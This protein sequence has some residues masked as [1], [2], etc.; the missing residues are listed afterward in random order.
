MRAYVRPC[1]AAAAAASLLLTPLPLQASAASRQAPAAP[2][3]AAV[4]EHAGGLVDD[5][6]E[7]V[8]RTYSTAGLGFGRTVRKGRANV[9]VGAVRQWLGLD[10]ANGNYYRK[11]FTL[12]AVGEHIEVWVAND[13]R[14]PER[15]CRPRDSTDVT[16][17]QVG[18]LVHEF[19]TT[20]WPRETSAF[21][22]PPGRDGTDPL[23]TGD[24][25]GDGEKTVTLV[26]NVRDDNFYT[27]PKAPTYIAGFFSPQINE[28]VDRN[29]MTIDAYDWKHRTGA[30]PPDEPTG[31]V[32]TSRPARPRMYEGTF[33]HEWQHLL[34]QYTDPD[35]VTWVNE[36]L[37]DYAQTLVGYVDASATI[38]HPGA[39]TH[40]TCFQGFAVVETKYN[41]NPRE[42]G[43]A[44]NSLT[45]W[46]EGSPAEVLA[47]YGN[48]YQFMLYLRDRFGAEALSRLHRDGAHQGLAGV[49]AALGDAVRLYGVLHDFQTMSLVDKTVGDD[50][51]MVG[52]PLARVTAPSLRATVN[53]ANPASYD[54]A[55]AAPNGADYV[56]LRDA[57]GHYLTGAEVTSARFTGART[58]P[59]LPLTWTVRDGALFSGR[60]N[61]IDAT[62]VVAVRVPKDDPAL[63]LQE[64]Y[65]AEN[66]YDYGYV[67]VSTD[68]GKSYTAVAGDHTV[69]GPLGPGVTGSTDGLQPHTYDLSAYAGKKIL[70]GFRYVSD[71]AV[72]EGGWYLDDISLG[73]VTISDGTS[74]AAF[75]S[76][77]QIVPDAVHAWSVRLIGLDDDG[78]RARQ[79]PVTQVSALR[80]YEKV[81]AVVSYD[82]PTGKLKQYA[83]YVL[84]ANGVIQ[85]GGS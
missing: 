9:E 52:V 30:T 67:T 65:G 33:A 4:P 63:T 18:A 28:L 53:L 39:D 32:C 74:L 26:D 42:C 19:D 11:D 22:T 47:D 49:Q 51:V 84:Q 14:F 44:Q 77:T 7:P 6:R 34:Q 54:W 64:A 72:D 79:V 8:R 12:R 1:L 76:P 71:G 40:L 55:G 31:D 85:P 56:R 21:S 70:L 81:V 24:F 35:E 82:E 29:V 37:S 27:F 68:G 48:A 16:D 38:Y 20:I 5:T 23:I 13:L 75:R 2:E 60:G 61:T 46:D 73:S 59:A 50:G 25:T 62:A 83:P 57:D 43:G 45:L 41:A 66:G 69:D 3:Q 10:D 58:L 15:D 36:G 17:A 78:P 80:A